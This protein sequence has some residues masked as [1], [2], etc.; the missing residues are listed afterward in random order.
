ME[1]PQ[2]QIQEWL[3]Q[4]EI[5]DQLKPIQQYAQEWVDQ[6]K[7]IIVTVSL[8]NPESIRPWVM[9]Q[10]NEWLI[11]PTFKHEA[12]CQLYTSVLQ[13]METIIELPACLSSKEI[14]KNGAEIGYSRYDISNQGRV[15]NRIGGLP[16]K[17]GKSNKDYLAYHL[18]NDN[19]IQKTR[20]T[21]QLVALLFIPN[22]ENKPT[23]D[24]I[25]RI[26]NDNRCWNLRWATSQEQNLNR[27]PSKRRAHSVYQ[28][29]LNNNFVEKWKSATEAAREMKINAFHLMNICSKGAVYREYRWFYDYMVE[30]DET[31]EWRP[32]YL[33]NHKPIEIS[34]K[35]RIRRPNG[36]IYEGR[37]DNKYQEIKLHNFITGERDPIKIHTLVATA[38]LGKHEGLEVN[39]KNGIKH[40]N[41]LE[42]LEW[43]THQE[44]MLHA[45]QTGLVGK[46]IKAIDEATGDTIETARDTRAV[47]QI[48]PISDNVIARYRGIAEAHRRTGISMTNILVVCQGFQRLANGWKW[49]FVNEDDNIEEIKKRIISRAKKAVRQIDPKTDR[50]I[51]EYPCAKI[52]AVETG[53]N[54]GAIA[55]VC[56][57]T[58]KTSG[59]FIW[60][61][62]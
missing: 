57:G 51:A 62:Y 3:E 38:F 25:N 26:G 50:I 43:V 52:A 46:Q 42:N 7:E 40:D 47:Q 56:R 48:D 23:V 1:T 36:K 13:A 49:K 45:H 5:E 11:N 60:E 16:F 32:S 27:K 2:T 44:N 8:E 58:A 18:T 30:V 9:D 29:D 55:N 61:Y 41:R 22:P 20:S 33:P 14:W 54:H 24:H 21:H 59:G 15:R 35:G 19:N 37:K 28:F 6:H 17:G 39:H 12:L 31:E 10:I 4:Q 34:S 53:L